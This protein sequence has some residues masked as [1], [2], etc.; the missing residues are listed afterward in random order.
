M[1][2]ITKV[3]ILGAGAVGAYFATTFFDAE[4]FQTSLVARGQ[5]YE[6]L[7]RDGL[8]VNGRSYLIAVT[9]P[10]EATAPADLIIVGLKHHHLTTALPDLKNLVGEQTTIISIMN[11]LDSEEIIAALYG[12][13]KVLYTIALGIDAVREGNR[14]TFTRPGKYY[15]GQATNEQIG[16]RVRRVQAA[17]DRAGI[18]Y[19][20]PVDMIRMLWWKFMINVGMNQASAVTRAPYGVFQTSPPARAVVGGLMGEVIALAG[21]A[22]VN[23]V[24]QDIEDWYTVLDTLSPEGKTSMLQDIEAGRKTEVEIF[25]GKI[26]ALGQEYGLPTPVNETVLHI[27]QVLEQ[28]AGS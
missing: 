24:E 12:W 17:F 26:V 9:H 10:D 4:G 1:Q 25:G 3:A 8:V 28:Q 13:D 7:R 11:G 6:R 19:E 2:E 16:E 18:A 22:G 21:A 27:I 20:T 23:L 5:R 15:F 14:I